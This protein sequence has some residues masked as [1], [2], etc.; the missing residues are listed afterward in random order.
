MFFVNTRSICND[1]RLINVVVVVV[2]VSTPTYQYN[3]SFFS[4]FVCFDEDHV[5]VKTV[6][7]E[8]IRYV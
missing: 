7:L 6:V 1:Y 3:D 8:P 2:V 4:M 5:Q